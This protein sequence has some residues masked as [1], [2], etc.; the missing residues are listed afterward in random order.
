MKIAQER[1]QMR[2]FYDITYDM[3]KKYDVIYDIIQYN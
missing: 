2:G 3:I 1:L